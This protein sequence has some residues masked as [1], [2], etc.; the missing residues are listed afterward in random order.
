VTKYI[1]IGPYG[2]QATRNS[3]R[4]YTHAVLVRYSKGRAIH[5]AGVRSSHEDRNFWYHHAIVNG[6]SEWL[7]KPNYRTIEQHQVEVDRMKRSSSEA[8]AGCSSPDEW[9]ALHKAKALAEIESK[10]WLVWHCV[11]WCGRYDLAVEQKMRWASKD[12]VDGCEIVEV[13]TR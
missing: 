7:D 5:W 6:T 3:D 1:A 12:G 10:D 4:V 2:S 8:L 11:A 13:K 9:F